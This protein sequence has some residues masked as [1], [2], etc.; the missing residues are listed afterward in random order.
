MVIEIDL[1]W[2]RT[3][4]RANGNKHKTHT[5]R[6]IGRHLL[7][8]SNYFDSDSVIRRDLDSKNIER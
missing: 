6:S 4:F 5:D 2:D 1:T 3:I 7:D 8:Q